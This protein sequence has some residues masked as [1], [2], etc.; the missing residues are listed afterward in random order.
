MFSPTLINEFRFGY[1]YG[2]F[3]FKQ[4]EF[5]NTN[6]APSLGMGGV[7]SGGALG[8]GLPLVTLSGLTGF[9]QP[10]YYPNHKSEDVYEFLDN[11]TK[12]LGS[13]SLKFGVLLQSERF[14]F[15]SPPNAR[16]TYSYS[17]YFTSLPGKSFTGYGAADFL[18]N[19]MDSATVPQYQHLDFSHW[20][21]GAYAQDDWRVTRNLTLNLGLRYDNFQP[22]KEVAGKFADFYLQPQ[23]PGKSTATL[24]YTRSQQN[25]PLAA[26]FTNL[27]AANGVPIHYSG[28][29]QLVNGQNFTFGPRV[30]F[31]YSLDPKT[32]L[33]GGIGLFYGGVENTG[34]RRQCR[35]ILSNSRPT[36]RAAQPARLAAAPLTE[37]L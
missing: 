18:E 15:L 14:T 10:G 27:L 28:N 3:G 6:L 32:V 24:T 23:G 11:V 35:T 19:Q 37:S 16:G 34:G 1:N 12:I 9:G 33:R 26:V 20:N 21:R 25:T 29:S 31:A 13:H 17:G 22:L 5:S 4:A 7:P 2:N 8:G 36:S 30:G